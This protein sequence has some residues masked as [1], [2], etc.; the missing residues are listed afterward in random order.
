LP[1]A[2]F[3]LVPSGAHDLQN[4]VPDAFVN[5]VEDFIASRASS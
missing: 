5:L 2:D 4:T 1:H 3:R